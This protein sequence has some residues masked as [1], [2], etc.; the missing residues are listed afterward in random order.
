MRRADYEVCAAARG[1][2]PLCVAIQ[3]PAAEHH[4]QRD[5]LRLGEPEHD[6]LVAADELDEE[7]LEPGQHG[8]QRE[9]RPG[10]EAV[11]PAPQQHGDGAHRE[12]L[13]DRRR[14]HGHVGRH[15]AVR[16]GHRPRPV[17]RDAVVAVAGE[18]AADPPDRVAR[19]QRRRAHVE[20]AALQA[21]RGAT[22][23]RSTA[24]AP[25]IAP[26][27]NTRPEPE[28][29]RAE[30]VALGVV[31][32]LGDPPQPRADD[33][34]DQRG[35]DELVG[36]VDAACRSPA[37]SGRPARRRRRSRCRASARTSAA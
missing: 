7:P 31:P 6:L 12:R 5:Q 17:P 18:L 37:G 13:V 4:R 30:Q 33:P 23:T 22:P 3:A 15:G 8:P 10:P 24:I 34:A 11:P 21:S 27:K 29:Q 36:P 19:G 14:V 35:E 20:R 9:Q 1:A 16:V 28:K 26:P 25:P 32:V 2:R